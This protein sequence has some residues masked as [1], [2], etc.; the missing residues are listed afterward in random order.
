MGQRKLVLDEGPDPPLEGSFEGN[1]CRPVVTYLRL[2]ASRIF[3]CPTPAAARP[4][5]AFAV[6][7]GGK[8]CKMLGGDA[9]LA[10]LLW[11]GLSA[12][13]IMIGGVFLP[14]SNRIE[15]HRISADR[16]RPLRFSPALKNDACSWDRFTLTLLTATT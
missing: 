4:T 15:S 12:V 13:G 3:A 14:A 9:A 5:S 7:R 2:S 6:A 8:T 11:S 16:F 1:I 10:K